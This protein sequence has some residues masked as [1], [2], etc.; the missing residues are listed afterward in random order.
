MET[1]TS[2]NSNATVTT[3]PSTTDKDVVPAALTVSLPTLSSAG[4]DTGADNGACSTNIDNINQEEVQSHQCQQ[5]NQKNDNENDDDDDSERNISPTPDGDV[6][7]SDNSGN[8]ND[9]HTN[10][11]DKNNEDETKNRN[12]NN[13]SLGLLAKRF[14]DLMKVNTKRDF[15]H[16]HSLNILLNYY[17]LSAFRIFVLLSWSLFNL[18]NF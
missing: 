6:V 11:N 8:S 12:N 14:T 5:Q 3:L 2:E 1:C 15:I 18:F 17:D 13:T 7:I 16:I 10:D 4:A 9:K